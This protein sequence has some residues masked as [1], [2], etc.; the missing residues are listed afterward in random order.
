MADDG[1]ISTLK[2]DVNKSVN[3][4]VKAV[5]EWNIETIHNSP[6]SRNTELFNWFN[7]EALPKLINKL[8][9]E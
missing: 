9:G 7:T 8:K 6:I 2:Q 1:K 4:P 5:Y 3:D